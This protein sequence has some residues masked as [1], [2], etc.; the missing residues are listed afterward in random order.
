MP[1]RAGGDP[2]RLT[3]PKGEYRLATVELGPEALEPASA[4]RVPRW[5]IALAVLAALNVAAW[6][7]FWTTHS[8]EREL[9]SAR[10]SAPWRSS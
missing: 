8:G 9:I 1:A 3:V 7:A 6:A 10:R 4:R 2:V 5:A